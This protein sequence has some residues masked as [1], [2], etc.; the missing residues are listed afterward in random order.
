MTLHGGAERGSTLCR[1]VTPDKGGSPQ[2][3]GWAIDG[4]AC[5]GVRWRRS[6]P[7]VGVT[8]QALCY[9]VG[10]RNSLKRDDTPVLAAWFLWEEIFCGDEG[11]RTE[12]GTDKRKAG[13]REPQTP[14]TS[15]SSKR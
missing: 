10:V 12:A 14:P 13:K 1:L 3:G 9:V 2:P 15:G 6:S 8:P 5:Y 4:R 11:G 7:R